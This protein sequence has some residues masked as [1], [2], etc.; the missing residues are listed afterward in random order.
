MSVSEPTKIKYFSG[1]GGGIAL[2][3]NGAA[4]SSPLS[5]EEFN[6]LVFKFVAGEAN[7][8]IAYLKVPESRSAVK[9][10]FIK[11]NF[12]SPAT[13]GTFKFAIKSYL[14]RKDLDALDSVTNLHTSQIVTVTNTSPANTMREL[15]FDITASTGKINSL[16]VVAGSTLRLEL[17]RETGDTDTSD[18]RFVP[19]S[20]EVII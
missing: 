1:G 12:Y 14:I 20:T 16:D 6:D 9:Q 7:K 15:S 10:G 3:W 8:V 19:A 17:Y 2:K 11:A 13:S 5:A 4:G 18:V